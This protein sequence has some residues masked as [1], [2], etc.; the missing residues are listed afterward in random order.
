[1]AWGIFETRSRQQV[2]G[3]VLL[4]ESNDDHTVFHNV[5]T[6][7]HRGKTIILVP[8]PSD[9]QNDPLNW[10]LWVR[11]LV[12]LLYGYCTL[13]IVGGI[14]PILSSLTLE[15]SLL[16]NVS[17]TKISLLTGY[18]LCATGASGIFISAVANKYGKRLIFLFSL[19]CA[20]G[21][22][23]WGG[24]ATS[25]DSLLGARILQGLSVAVFES[26]IFSIIGDLY[27]VHER[28]LRVAVMTTCIVGISNL[29]PVLAGKISMSLGWRWVFWLLAVFLGIALVLALLFGWETAYVRK[30]VYN[31]DL[32]PE[33]NL[34]TN[35]AKSTRA[36]ADQVED[37]REACDTITRH[38]SSLLPRKSITRLLT[39]W[40]GEYT[41]KSL[42]RLLIEPF[43]V[44]ANP[45]V[46]WAVLLISFPTLW[47]VAVNLLIA[48]IFSAPPYLLDTAELGYMSAGPAVG[49]LLG[50]IAAGAMSDPI[51]EWASRRNKGVYEPEFRLMLI[52]P[53]I[54]TSAIGY[55]PF[56]Y[57]AEAGKGPV[58]M[59]TLW[60]ISAASLQFIM[61][62]VGTYIV[63][64]YR[65]M[66]IEIFI[67]TMVVKN[68]LFF[69]F[70]FF[71]NTWIVEWGPA[72]MFYCIGGIQAAFCLTTVPMWSFGKLVRAWW[73]SSK[74]GI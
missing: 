27:Y 3:T 55:F 45:A 9:D 66:N 35:D 52:I 12:A 20:L 14:G 26:V 34:D 22:T 63:D 4:S 48:Q 28:G 16:F 1:M 72:K 13:L 33:D 71:L 29:P 70:S 8:Q 47:L 11:D 43:I 54:I 24:Y 50:S 74:D 7:K 6:T 57:L 62:A 2:A 65:D 15:L 67:I 21:G 40:S 25:Y 73:Y 39:P 69:G 41:S 58:I 53:A 36:D 44:L 32:T 59:S 51:I 17:F 60:G 49:G 23:I 56:G 64:S 37:A 5:K 18:S 61:T 68:F 10:P 19:A 42:W 38:T 46:I 30:T 31:T